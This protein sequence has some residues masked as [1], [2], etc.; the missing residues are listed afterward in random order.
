MTEAIG[1][2]V[3]ILLAGFF[4]TIAVIGVLIFVVAFLGAPLAALIRF[5]RG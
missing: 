4:A 5:I 2:F 1:W 3:V